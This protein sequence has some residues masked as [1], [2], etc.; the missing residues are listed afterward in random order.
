MNFLDRFSKN[1]QIL[2][3]TQIHPLG[4]EFFYVAGQTQRQTDGKTDMTK[5]IVAYKCFGIW[6]YNNP[7]VKVG[8]HYSAILNLWTTFEVLFENWTKNKVHKIQIPT[9]K[10]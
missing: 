8:K 10:V 7:Q 1:I 6:F 3:F 9:Q 2:N 4:A 5:G